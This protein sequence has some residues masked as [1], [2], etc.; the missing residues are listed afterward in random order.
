MIIGEVTEDAHAVIPI[1]I[2]TDPSSLSDIDV[3]IDTAFDGYLTLP[4]AAIKELGLLQIADGQLILA[5]GTDRASDSYFAWVIID[6]VLTKVMILELD[7]EPLIG[8]SLL[9]G[10]SAYIEIVPNGQVRL[11]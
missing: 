2:G 9:L 6:D 1:S 11:E 5:D 8:M 3:R 4:A 10:F 7:C